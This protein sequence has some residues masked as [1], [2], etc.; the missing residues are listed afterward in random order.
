MRQRRSL[1]A[2][3]ALIGGIVALGGALAAGD[4]RA[5]DAP[6]INAALVAGAS[7]P[8]R[9]SEFG[10]FAGSADAPAAALIPYTLRTPLF[11]DYAEKRR[12]IY[13]PPG[14]RMTAQGD[15]QIAFPVGSAIIKSFGY[16]QPSGFRTI[17]TRVLLR[18]AAGWVALPYIWR[19][20]GSDADLRL[21][22]GRMPVTFTDPAGRERTISYA[23][24]NRN[25]CKECH[26]DGEAMTPI[27]PKLRNIELAPGAQA[28]VDGAD[29]SAARLPVWNDAA[30]GSIAARARAYLDVNCAHCHNPTGAASNSG[31]FLEY[32]RPAGS[33]IGIGKRPVAAGRGSG[34]LDYAIAPGHPEA[35]FL[36]Y[37]LRS[38]EPGIA[39]P[40]VGRGTVHDEG[41][42]LLTEWIAGMPR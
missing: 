10:F 32:Q 36:L 26:R 6:I 33:A 5:G 19:A 17:E 2:L 12:F 27:G 1:A 9:L 14:T 39:M 30:T 41:V 16:A 31:L 38:T 8:A 15:G 42:R 22:G 7:Q 29:W 23:V 13:L 24:P 11:S 25:Q 3:V 21:A 28:M 20:D 40:E 35:S 4:A 37:R 18:R 34:G